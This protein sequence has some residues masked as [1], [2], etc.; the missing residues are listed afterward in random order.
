VRNGFKVGPDYRKPAAPVAESW[1]DAAD[2]RVSE[3]SPALDQWWTVFHDPV[4]DRLIQQAAAQNL[5]LQQAGFR[6]LQARAQLGI[7]R[8]EVFPQQQDM[9]GFYRRLA[10]GG[11]YFDQW[12]WG[13]VAWELTWVDSVGPCSGRRSPECFSRGLRRACW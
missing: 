8:G 13:S 11:E 3:E 9:S 6:V 5:T 12:D 4:L 1:I 7:V 2:S 10:A